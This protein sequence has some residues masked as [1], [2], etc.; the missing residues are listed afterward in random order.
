[1]ETYVI[2]VLKSFAVG[3]DFSLKGLVFLQL[4]ME[5]CQVSVRF[6]CRSLIFFF[7]PIRELKFKQKKYHV[8]NKEMVLFHHWFQCDSQVAFS[9]LRTNQVSGHTSSASRLNSWNPCAASSALCRSSALSFILCRL[10]NTS[11]LLLS[12]LESEKTNNWKSSIHFLFAA[13]FKTSNVH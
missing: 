1:M 11:F 3:L 13:S 6:I 12:I 2:Q 10:S 7:D 9:K 5:I 4:F 8:S